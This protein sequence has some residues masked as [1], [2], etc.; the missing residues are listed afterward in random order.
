[1]MNNV[2]ILKMQ[3]HEMIKLLQKWFQPIVYQFCNK[4]G[5]GTLDKHIMTGDDLKKIVLQFLPFLQYDSN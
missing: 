3:L 2:N 1:M 5:I 4:K